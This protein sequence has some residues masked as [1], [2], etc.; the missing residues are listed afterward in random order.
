MQP[1]RCV[2]LIP[3]EAFASDKHEVETFL[4]KA[5]LIQHK[6]LLARADGMAP[7]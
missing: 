4:T 2:Q 6:V 1:L 3:I 7:Y 5:G